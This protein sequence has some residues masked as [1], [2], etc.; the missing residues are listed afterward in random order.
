MMGNDRLECSVLAWVEFPTLSVCCVIHLMSKR[1]RSHPFAC[2]M[3]GEVCLCALTCTIGLGVPARAPITRRR[4]DSATDG[5]AEIREAHQIRRN[6]KIA[7]SWLF[8]LQKD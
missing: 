4:T 7:M 5:S 3:V 8:E 1:L 2:I 6:P